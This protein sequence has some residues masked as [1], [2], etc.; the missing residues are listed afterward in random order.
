MKRIVLALTTVGAVV[1]FGTS[2]QAQQFYFGPSIP[3]VNHDRHHQDL[4]HREYHRELDHREAHRYPQSWQQHEQ[5]HDNL[6][7][8]AYHDG[9]EHGG[10][11]QSGAYYPRQSYYQNSYYFPGQRFSFWYG[12]W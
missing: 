8:E 6:N 11:H 10:A 4:G 9:L 2:A 1:L 12:G 7:H 5:L 3:S